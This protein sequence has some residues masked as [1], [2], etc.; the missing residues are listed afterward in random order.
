MKLFQKS[1]ILNE[2]KCNEESHV[3]LDVS[4]ILHSSEIEDS[5]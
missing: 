1:I 3:C 2:M 5:T 4:K